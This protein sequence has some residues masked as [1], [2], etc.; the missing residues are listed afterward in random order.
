MIV[1]VLE[2]HRHIAAL[3]HQV[4]LWMESFNRLP[5]LRLVA[6]HTTTS[7]L[8]GLSR[9][10]VRT[11]TPLTSLWRYV[12]THFQICLLPQTIMKML[13]EQYLSTSPLCCTPRRQA[14]PASSLRWKSTIRFLVRSPLILISLRGHRQTLLTSQLTRLTA[15]K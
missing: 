6:V 15:V 4:I 3:D 7:L 12:L 2:C 14:Q 11:Y 5:P 1:F 9:S 10:L 8:A 13:L